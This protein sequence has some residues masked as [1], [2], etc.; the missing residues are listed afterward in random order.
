VGG[1]GGLLYPRSCF[2]LVARKRIGVYTSGLLNT[3]V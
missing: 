1:G 3:C 2:R